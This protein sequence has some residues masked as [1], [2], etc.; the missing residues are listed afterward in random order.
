MD[1]NKMSKSKR[2]NY[3]SFFYVRKYL[4]YYI[5]LSTINGK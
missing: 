3:E 4:E 1:T 5:H 2:T